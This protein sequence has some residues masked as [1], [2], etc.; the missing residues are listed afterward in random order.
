MGA[1]L[2]ADEIYTWFTSC[3]HAAMSPWGSAMA[4]PVGSG[5]FTRPSS[6]F[7]FLPDPVWFCLA[8]RVE[9]LCMDLC[10]HRDGRPMENPRRGVG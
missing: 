5:S 1:L 9:R 7:C 8:W 10:D 3:T 6:L 2:G 4:C